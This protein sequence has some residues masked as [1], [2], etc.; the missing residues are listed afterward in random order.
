MIRKEK[1]VEL[2]DAHAKLEELNSGRLLVLSDIRSRT[3]FSLAS[4]FLSH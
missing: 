1:V 4:P 2:V 3:R